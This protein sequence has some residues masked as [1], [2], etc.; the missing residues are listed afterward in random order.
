MKKQKQTKKKIPKKS[1]DSYL[2]EGLRSA[3]LV[4]PTLKSEKE[5]RAQGNTCIWFDVMQLLCPQA[6]TAFWPLMCPG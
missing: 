4:K 2:G 1:M 5:A 6:W 3:E